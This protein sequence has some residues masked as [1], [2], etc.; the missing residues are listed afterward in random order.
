MEDFLRKFKKIISVTLTGIAG[1]LLT[2]AGLGLIN[3][4]LQLILYAG[5]ILLFVAILI[6]VFS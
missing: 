4:S 6:Y 2:L 5:I 3:L 1:L